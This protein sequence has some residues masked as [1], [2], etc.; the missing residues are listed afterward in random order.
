[1][2]KRKGPE[3]RSAVHQRAII[4]GATITRHET[5][6]PDTTVIEYG[7]TAGCYAYF[8]SKRGS[9]HIALPFDEVVKL[10]HHKDVEL[11]IKRVPEIKLG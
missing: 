8:A 2:R 3:R 7:N 10:W 11:P 1:M 9:Y 5:L 4:A 6:D